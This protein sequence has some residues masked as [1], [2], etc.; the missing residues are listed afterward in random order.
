MIV[1][2]K[3]GRGFLPPPFSFFS[4]ADVVFP[5]VQHTKFFFIRLCMLFVESGQNS[6]KR[7]LEGFP[8]SLSEPGEAKAL[9]LP[10]PQI[11]PVWVIQT[12]T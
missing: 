11:D 4:S 5:D 10:I 1:I 6:Q 2:G 8:E 12:G 7:E 3:V 9:P